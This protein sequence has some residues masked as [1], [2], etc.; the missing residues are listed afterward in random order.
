MRLLIFILIAFSACT[1][2]P[3][4]SNTP[5]PVFNQPFYRFQ[6]EAITRF[7]ITRSFPGEERWNLVAHKEN[8]IW[9]LIHAPVAI[10]DVRADAGLLDHVLDTLDTFAPQEIAPS[11]PNAD[12]LES[13]GLSPPRALIKWS[14][15]T[16]HEL[17]LGDTY[18]QTQRFALFENSK[19]LLAS[20]AFLEM[21]AHIQSWEFFRQRTFLM[22]KLDDRDRL[23]Y[24]NPNKKTDGS[25]KIQRLGSGWE[26]LKQQNVS[27][28]LA[29]ILENLFHQRIKRFVDDPREQAALEIQFKTKKRETL[30][31]TG[32]DGSK[33][34]VSFARP[35]PTDARVWAQ[36]SARENLYFELFPA[37]IDQIDAYVKALT[38]ATS[39]GRKSGKK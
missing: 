10:L 25:L 33:Q 21:L 30:S 8:G 31:W 18:G 17:T 7:E 27:E 29:P 9:K 39:T 22:G 16:S 3:V 32:R 23:E 2:S 19:P 13:M 6:K 11:N 28:V 38:Q 26:T 35:N 1:R 37:W 4:H 36:N 12:A 15:T 14:G 24:T 34:V 20:G 5:T